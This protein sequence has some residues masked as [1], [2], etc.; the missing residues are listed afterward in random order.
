MMPLYFY[1]LI[2]SL[3]VPMLY[4]IFVEDFI[5]HWK[6]FSISTTIIAVIYL[7]W[8]AIFTA[9]GI[10]GFNHDY[11]L[12]IFFFKLPLEEIL[13][14]FI[15]PFCSLL[16]H[17][18]FYS[19]L[20]NTKLSK[21]ITYGIS[22]LFIVIS[23]LLIILNYSKAYT[24]VN[25]LFLLIVLILGIKYHFELLQKFFITFLIIL[26]PF[27]IVNGILTGIITETPIVWY[28]NTQNLGIRIFT[29][30][31]EDAGYAFSMLFGNLMIFEYLNQRQKIEK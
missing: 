25:Y 19:V 27:L 6:N 9:Q 4:S 22:I 16:I 1:V 11:C 23:A 17:Y 8:D 30:P 24:F 7:V 2:G 29:I 3:A 5:I 31:I 21:K 28:D 26:I 14:F 13:F 12:N 15:I 20:P 10:W 18:A